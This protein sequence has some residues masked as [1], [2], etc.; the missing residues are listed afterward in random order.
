MDPRTLAD[1]R[2]GARCAIA[3]SCIALDTDDQIEIGRLIQ[4]VANSDDR[5][6]FDIAYDAVN[7]YL[8]ENF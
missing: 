6:P 8:A 7:D 3:E 1:A 5:R 2:N 4:D